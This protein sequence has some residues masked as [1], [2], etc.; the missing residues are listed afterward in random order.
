MLY[1]VCSCCCACGVL[2]FRF[3]AGRAAPG[4]VART[5]AFSMLELRCGGG[6]GAGGETGQ[7]QRLDR[8]IQD[9]GRL[10]PHVLAFACLLGVG[11]WVTITG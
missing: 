6:G 8:G 10:Q 1:F 7:V 3:F 2:R 9:D 11:V 5:V 4:G